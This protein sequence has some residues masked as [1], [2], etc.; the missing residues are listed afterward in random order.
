MPHSSHGHPLPDGQNGPVEEPRR[1]SSLFATTSSAPG[2][3]DN[4]EGLSQHNR[5]LQLRNA[6]FRG[7][8][9]PFRRISPLLG[10]SGIN[11][12][13]YTRSMSHEQ[14]PP[15]IEKRM[16]YGEELPGN[17]IN[18]MQEIHKM[19][20]KKKRSS[21]RPGFGAIFEDRKGKEG[22]ADGSPTSWYNEESAH[23]S[24]V[25]SAVTPAKIRPLREV[26]LNVKT[27]P[28]LGFP[29]PNHAK[30]RN[31]TRMK[32][33]SASAEIAQY[34]EH[35]ESELASAHA[36][37][38]SQPSPKTSK[39][40]AAKL[41][42]MVNE[43]RDIKHENF[44]WEKRFDNMVQE[45][46]SKRLEADLEV[47]SRMRMLEDEL[48]MKNTKMKEFEWE[49]ENMRAKMR[50]LEGLEEINFN[51]EKRIE[52]LTNL[53]V[54]SPTK[55]DV[56]SA[57]T[58]PV[59]IDPTKRTPRPR[60][61][62]PKVPSS[63]ARPRLSLA[64]VSESGAGRTR[65][66]IWPS[67]ASTSPENGVIHNQEEEDA[68]SPL[69]QEAHIS[70]LYRR[71]SESS[72]R[73]SRNSSL[74]RSTPSSTSKRTSMRSS[75]C[76]GPIA[77]GLPDEDHKSATKQRK[78]R[79]FMSGSNSLKPLILPAASAVTSHPATAPVF[80]SIET[81]AR[82]D[83]S[84]MS[85]DP[86]TDFLSKLSDN[87]AE[88]TPDHL[89]AQ[90]SP[91][92]DQER[93]LNVLEG[94][95]RS[96][97]QYRNDIIRHLRS[98]SQTQDMEEQSMGFR[99]ISSE[100][101]KRRSRPRSLQQELEEAEIAQ[102]DTSQ[103]Q[104][105]EL[106]ET[107]NT[108][109]PAH[110]DHDL[111]KLSTTIDPTAPK[112]SPSQLHPT[113]KRLPDDT[114]FTPK[115]SSKDLYPNPAPAPLLKAPPCTALHPSNAHGFF[116]RLNN[117]ITRTKQEPF[118][119]AQRILINA[120][121]D[122]TNRLL[123][124]IGWWLLGLVYGIRWRKR[125]RA[126]TDI[127]ED[128]DATLRSTCEWEHHCFPPK[129]AGSFD[130][131][132]ALRKGAARG[133]WLCPPHVDHVSGEDRIA[134][135][136]AGPPSGPQRFPCDQC[137]EP[138]SRKTLRLWLKFSLA[139][140]LAVGL[141]VKNGPASLVGPGTSCP[142]NGCRHAQRPVGEREPLLGRQQPPEPSG[143]F[144]RSERNELPRRSRVGSGGS[145]GVDSGYG[146]ITFACDVEARAL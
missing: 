49:I 80:P 102:E 138:T 54:Q 67:D 113:P 99:P 42:A 9:L 79:R 146:S 129:R 104:H 53:L 123:G 60:S 34:V 97:E 114:D 7:T 103:A 73:R 62:L 141:A 52:A 121:S 48:E 33:R 86:T 110:K 37:L 107:S 10:A 29:S 95:R 30:G 71:Q 40:R 124:G 90:R 101:R 14:S 87:T 89:E 58:S 66:L 109:I 112:R 1:N 69:H 26:S 50:D 74:Y 15:S 117:L 134:V 5:R 92:W 98:Q 13:P 77:W 68:L 133:S 61:M 83:A 18:I 108:L 105:S 125:R 12:E 75:G 35:L 126:D 59:R 36:K 3:P 140:V 32:H 11:V 70:P 16:I 43:N 85:F 137:V 23:C 20:T 4:S 139:L 44:E 46:R 118:I 91:S 2:F 72:D 93:T 142:C 51:L 57:S 55:L 78:M 119:L 63:P 27:P 38:D 96:T 132:Q 45:E 127:V 25:A 144:T 76:F 8:T 82:R 116:T 17:P 81:T 120:W 130:A 64:T 88:S 6:G 128:D 41:R 31:S 122:G 28:S 145:R 135:L 24:P 115:S 56:T 94:K 100:N 19:S 111:L 65:S 22:A 84:D 143:L 21:P 131:E 106:E 39:L 136:P 47:R